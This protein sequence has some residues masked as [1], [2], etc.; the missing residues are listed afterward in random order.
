M[1]PK[2]NV[3]MLSGYMKSGKDLVADYLVSNHNFV[4][5]AFATELKKEV[6]ELYNISLQDTMTQEGKEKVVQISPN[7]RKTIRNILIEHGLLQRQKNTNFYWVDKVLTEMENNNNVR[8]VI[9]DLR[10]PNEY[11]RIKDCQK[12]N[13]HAV[14]IDRFDVP[15]L[16]DK[17]ET[18]M[19][20]FEFCNII[21]NKESI[22]KLYSKIDSLLGKLDLTK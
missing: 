11:L 20:D 16:V 19:D 17:S 14:R 7:E 6:C 22:E 4:K 10:F 2:I 13:V 1:T 8:V 3:L 21:E 15:P 18:A 5:Y 9:S 12:F